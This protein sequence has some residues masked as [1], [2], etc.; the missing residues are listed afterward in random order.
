MPDKTVNSSEGAQ[1]CLPEGP[2]DRKFIE[3]ARMESVSVTV[4]AACVC[5]IAKCSQFAMILK[6]ILPVGELLTK[7]TKPPL[8]RVR[9]H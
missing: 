7:K 1:I 9:F 8:I 4:M 6:F 3:S 5:L 2:N